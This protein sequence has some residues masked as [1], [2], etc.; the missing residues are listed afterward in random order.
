MRLLLRTALVGFVFLWFQPAMA[1]IEDTIDGHITKSKQ[2]AAQEKWVLS[3]QQALFA[4]SQMTQEDGHLANP[5]VYMLIARSSE[6]LGKDDMVVTYAKSALDNYLYLKE[7]DNAMRAAIMLINAYLRMGNVNVAEG[8]QNDVTALVGKVTSSELRLEVDL[9]RAHIALEK[10]NAHE[11]AALLSQINAQYSIR[12]FLYN[13]L[14]IRTQLHLGNSALA[15]RY[16]NDLYKNKSIEIET[17]LALKLQELHIQALEMEGLYGEAIAVLKQ[18]KEAVSTYLKARNQAIAEDVTAKYDLDKK[19]AENRA[20]VHENERAALA[21]KISE[22]RRE[23]QTM[24]VYLSSG[25]A[26]LIVVICIAQFFRR[27]A[28]YQMVNFDALTGIPN[29]H[30]LMKNG[31]KLLSSK[32]HYPFSVILFDIDDFKAINDTYGHEMGDR[33]LVDIGRIG[34]RIVPHGQWFG[35]LGGEEFVM[36]LSETEAQDAI[37]IAEAMLEALTQHAWSCL[38]LNK[39]VTASLGVTTATEFYMGDLD[40]LLISADKAMYKA[41]A[42]GKA[43]VRFL[44]AIASK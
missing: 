37:Q 17:S 23:M 21:V 6:Q 36:I 29:R 27:R 40:K 7:D 44:D 42:D 38:G 30:A 33:V 41:K 32:K 16:I 26:L 24:I 19:S 35:R 20:L 9:V 25:L 12:P 8:V 4:L 13:Y 11:S 39:P 1:S 5:L 34:A 31:R 14:D 43:K 28:L 3:Q 2:Y 15:L 10:G 22:D 18:H